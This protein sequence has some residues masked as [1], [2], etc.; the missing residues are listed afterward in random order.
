MKPC[1]FVEDVHPVLV[2]VVAAAQRGR[3]HGPEHRRCAWPAGSG[4]KCVRNTFFEPGAL[5]LRGRPDTFPGRAVY[6]AS[7]SSSG[8]RLPP[9]RAAHLPSG[10]LLLLAGGRG[11]GRAHGAPRGRGGGRR[12]GAR[13]ARRFRSEPVRAAALVLG[14][15][16]N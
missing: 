7:E 12:R 8:Q 13:R 14:S 10:P 5:L 2:L 6:S 16:S 15:R 3:L 9:G 1:G 4:R 11:A